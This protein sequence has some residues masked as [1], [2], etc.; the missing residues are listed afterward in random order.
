MTNKPSI[1]LPS[2]SLPSG[3]LPSGRL[4]WVS[5][6]LLGSQLTMLPLTLAASTL[7]LQTVKKQTEPRERLLDGHVEAV[8][9]STVSAQTG[10]IITEIN[11][12]VDDLV[13]AGTVL[14]RIRDTQQQAQLKQ[15]KANAASA[16]AKLAEAR[17]R[18]R[19]IQGLLNKNLVSRAAFDTAQA[20]LKTATA[21]QLI[22]LAA[23]RQAREQLAYTVVKA[24]FTGVVT[25]RYVE[26]GETTQ[27]GQPLLTGLSLE[28]LRVRAFIPQQLIRA[29][30]KRHKV[31]V[32]TDDGKDFTINT[33]TI[34]P[35][36]DPKSNTFQ[37]RIP[38]PQKI[39][40]LYPGMLVKVAFAIGQQ[41]A[42][43]VPANAVIQRS[44]VSA[45]YVRTKEG[46]ISLRQIRRGRLRD[47]GMIEVLAGLEEGEQVVVNPLDAV[48]LRSQ[49]TAGKKP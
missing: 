39:T 41:Q 23:N 22:S 48:W 14:L 35:Y 13:Q 7:Q 47:N 4:L 17:K 45:V 2:I 1:P 9:R 18:F 44:E 3:R 24:P 36:A 16:N 21:Q 25:K 33:F 43:L 8:N 10:G 6:L 38:L 15:A 37:V 27:P 29:V 49:K 46:S 32:L 30:R 42:L 26:I 34:Y 20:D 11:V 40:G 31:R 12:D 5:L 19:R 28:R